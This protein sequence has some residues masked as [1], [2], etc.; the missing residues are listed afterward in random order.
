MLCFCSLYE[1]A[2]SLRLARSFATSLLSGSK[3]PSAAFF[4]L[5]RA[6]AA[7][8]ADL[9][10]CFCLTLSSAS[11]TLAFSFSFSGLVTLDAPRL[12]L[13]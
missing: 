11:A 7:C 1:R 4:A 13:F 6:M 9:S 12:C 8:T 10:P 3:L 2:C 5:A